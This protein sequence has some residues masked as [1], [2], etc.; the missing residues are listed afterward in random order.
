M[1]MVHRFGA[2]VSVLEQP[3]VL[4]HMLRM[5]EMKTRLILFLLGWVWHSSPFWRREIKCFGTAQR[6]VPHAEED[7]NEGAPNLRA[8]EAVDVE[9]ERKVHQLQ[10][11]G[12]RAEHLR[13][14]GNIG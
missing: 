10:I 13:I 9:V 4:F 6:A 11:V 8:A 2:L 12:H 1:G 3:S 5:T 7:G 14:P